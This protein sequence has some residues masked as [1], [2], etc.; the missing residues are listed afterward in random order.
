MEPVVHQAWNHGFGE[1]WLATLQ[2]MGVAEDSPLRNPEQ[3]PY[4]AL[5]PPVQSQADA[6]DEQETLSMRELVHAINT[7]VE[8]VDFEVT[9]NPYA[10]E[11]GQGQTLATDQP[12]GNAPA[13]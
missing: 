12:I 2:A 3:I 11:G 1:G 13:Q 8:M 6:V 5:A 7:H 4:L 10:A 9:S